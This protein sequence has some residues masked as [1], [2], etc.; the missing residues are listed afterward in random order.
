MMRFRVLILMVLVMVCAARLHASPQPNDPR[1]IISGGHDGLG[2]CTSI[3]DLD[4]TFMANSSGGGAFCFT[5][6]SSED[7]T[8][9]E[10]EAPS[11]TGDIITC[12]GSSFSHCVV[13]PPSG[14]FTIIDFSGGS[15]ILISESFT[16]DLGTSGWTPDGEFGAFANVPE[17]STLAFCLVGLAPLLRRQRHRFLRRDR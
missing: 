2:P 7:W 10:I 15:G 6:N 12:G 3:T 14:D 1:I 13:M 11:P 16:V 17:P 5:N 9:L 8:S 4:F